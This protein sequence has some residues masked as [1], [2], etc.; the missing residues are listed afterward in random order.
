MRSVAEVD[1]AFLPASSPRSQAL[2]SNFAAVQAQ[3][4]LVLKSTSSL[5][6]HLSGSGSRRLVKRVRSPSPAAASTPVAREV[7]R[8]GNEYSERAA[9]SQKKRSV[10]R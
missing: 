4:Q 6:V 3:T 8:N 7:E 9:P 5:E 10:R 1:F 2:K